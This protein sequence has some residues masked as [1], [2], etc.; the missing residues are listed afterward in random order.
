MTDYTSLSDFDSV[1]TERELASEI[2]R[3]SPP[4]RDSPTMDQISRAL[5]QL[6]DTMRAEVRN[7]V[8]AAERRAVEAVVTAVGEVLIEQRK[9]LRALEAEVAT[10]KAE[11][12][13]RLKVVEPDQGVI[14]S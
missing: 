8:K 5:D 14:A 4:R 12:G 9:K 3:S 7:E 6:R 10:L 13:K 2:K 1:P 11:R